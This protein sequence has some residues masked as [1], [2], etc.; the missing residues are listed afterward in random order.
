MYAG[1]D[2]IRVP[3]NQISRMRRELEA[4]G[5]PVKGFVTKE[6]EGHG[7]GKLEN[8]VDLYTQ[9]LAFIKEQIG[10]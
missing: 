7:Y 8:N 5:N 2:D 6:N 1:L 3:F 9:M 10:Q 4:S